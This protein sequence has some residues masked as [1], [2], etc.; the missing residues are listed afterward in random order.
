VD[1]T[2]E[3]LA[4]ARSGDKGD[5]ANIGVIARKPEYMD[6]LWSALTPEFIG[7]VFAPFMENAGEVERFY[8]PGSH[9]IN[10]LMN[11][12]LGGGGI[13]SLRNDA[14]AKGFAQI[15]LAQTISVP[16]ET[17]KAIKS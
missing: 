11:R 12:S 16:A 8:L 7:D 9:A 13:A 6:A 17:A 2:V 5:K 3:Q 1:I 10:V 4:W 14:Q 15:L